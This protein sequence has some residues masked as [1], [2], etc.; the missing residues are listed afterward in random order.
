MI[1]RELLEMFRQDFAETVKELE[2]KYQLEIELGKITYGSDSFKASLGV[3]ERVIG[4]STRQVEFE[5]LASRY[6][7]KAEQFGQEIEIDGC[8][9]CICGIEPKRRKYPILLERLSDGQ[10][11]VFTRCAVQQALAI[12]VDSGKEMIKNK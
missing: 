10:Q 11:M 12:R 3:H 9:Y 8:R 1:T 7:L 6:D 5:K 4:K 2:E